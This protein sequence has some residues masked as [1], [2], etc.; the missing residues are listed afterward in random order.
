MEI[1]LGILQLLAAIRG[2]AFV[3][4]VIALTL[5]ELCNASRSSGK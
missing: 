1:A 3:G 4:G 5:A 2:L